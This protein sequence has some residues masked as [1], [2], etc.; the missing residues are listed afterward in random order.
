MEKREDRIV[1]IALGIAGICIVGGLMLAAFLAGL[2]VARPLAANTGNA[3]DM[4]MIKKM[5]ASKQG[6]GFNPP[7][8]TIVIVPGKGGAQFTTPGTKLPAGNTVTWVNKTGQAQTLVTDSNSKNIVIAPG[9]TASMSF[10]EG[11]RNYSWHLE[12]NPEASITVYVGA[13]G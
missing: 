1:Y 4:A 7:P 8:N 11:G 9:E 3:P 5:L 13:R 12:S 10:P 6:K 2:L